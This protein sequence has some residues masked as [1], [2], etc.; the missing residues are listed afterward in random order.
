MNEQDN[1]FHRASYEPVVKLTASQLALKA[2]LATIK[3]GSKLTVGIIKILTSSTLANT[4]LS[5]AVGTA[6][7]L[8]AQA[9]TAG[10]DP[11]AVAIMSAFWMVHGFI[12]ILRVW[13]A[14]RPATLATQ[15]NRVEEATQARDESLE[16]FGEAMKGVSDLL[17]IGSDLKAGKL[18]EAQANEKLRASV[19]ETIVNIGTRRPLTAKALVAQLGKERPKG[20]AK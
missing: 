7:L 8:A 20:G 13:R 11:L 19:E 14:D 6:F 16:A 18:T 9:T 10:Q 4:V 17:V 15:D 2:L 5:G 3:S 1:P 12:A